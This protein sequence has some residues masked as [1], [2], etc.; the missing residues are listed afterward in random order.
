MFHGQNN[1]SH[2]NKRNILIWL[3]LALQAG[4][5][6]AG[7]FLGCHRFVTHTTGFATHFGADL[8]LGDLTAAFSMATVP[9]FFL[10]GCMFSAYFVD[11]RISRNRSPK[12]EVLL[13]TMVLLLALMALLGYFG[14]LGVFGDEYDGRGDYVLISILALTMG[15]QNASIT[16]ASGAIVRTTH[17]TGITT[18]LGIGLVRILTSSSTEITKAQEKKANLMRMG[19]ILFFILGST[20]GSFIFLK[21]GYIGFLLPSFTA[22]FILIFARRTKSRSIPASTK[23]RTA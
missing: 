4:A 14:L 2:Y 15:I 9:I 22:L 17:L 3:A 19:I 8:A 6:N 21:F 5:V 12:Y 18:D 1:L 10:F 13:G 20:L 7:G 16:S 23:E 11:R